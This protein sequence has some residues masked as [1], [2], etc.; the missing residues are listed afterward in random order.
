MLP[1][2]TLS[3][4]VGN[5]PRGGAPPIRSARARCASGADNPLRPCRA[6]TSPVRT[7][8]SVPRASRSSP[9]LPVRSSRAA[10]ATPASTDAGAVPQSAARGWLA[11]GSHFVFL[12]EFQICSERGHNPRAPMFVSRDNQA[13]GCEGGVPV[14]FFH[15]VTQV[16]KRIPSTNRPDYLNPHCASPPPSLT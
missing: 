15:S 8:T 11:R 2:E 14:A 9:R 16:L 4:S 7:A 5:G 13:W 1:L 3:V 6:A 10:K 12:R